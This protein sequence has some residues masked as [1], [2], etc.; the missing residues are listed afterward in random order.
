MDHDVIT[1]VEVNRRASLPGVNRRIESRA[2]PL[3]PGARRTRDPETS[4]R[5]SAMP[6]LIRRI[7]FLLALTLLMVGCRGTP[8]DTL[9]P[10]NGDLLACPETPNCVHTGHGHPEG[11]SPLMVAAE[12]ADASRDEIME[13]VAEAVDQLPRTAI[14]RHDDRYIHA[15]SASLI[16]RFVDDLEVLLSD[17]GSELIVRSAARMGQSDMGVNARRVEALHQALYERG[18]LT[19]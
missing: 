16:F 12:W 9:G 5:K 18:V 11:T 14:H 3:H 8:P 2:P 13:K 17:D 6:V 4:G 15:E 1:L 7:L 10:Q 19:R